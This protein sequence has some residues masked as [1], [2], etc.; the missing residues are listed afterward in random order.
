MQDEF[1]GPY[2][3]L[4]VRFSSRV[5]PKGRNLSYDNYRARI[6]DTINRY[7]YH[8]ARQRMNEDA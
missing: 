2:I 7:T 4:S 1:H 6:G 8:F 3:K 5:Y